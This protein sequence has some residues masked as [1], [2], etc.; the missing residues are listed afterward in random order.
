MDTIS[1]G[2]RGGTANIV[3]LSRTLIEAALNEIMDA[4]ADEVCEGSGT[5]RNG[6]RE[7]S[8]T[9]SVGPIVLRIPKLR[10]GTYFPERMVDRYGRT[11]KAV[12]AAVRE[13]YADGVSTRKAGGR[14]KAGR[15]QDELPAGQQDMRLHLGNEGLVD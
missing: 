12:V 6:Y 10:S 4:Q 11:D 2:G 7:R 15:G 1:R 13:M 14:R 8:L 3:E 9:T 5:V